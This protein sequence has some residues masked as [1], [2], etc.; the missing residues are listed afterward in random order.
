MCNSIAMPIA[1][2]TR[3]ATTKGVYPYQ[4]ALASYLRTA[5]FVSLF[6]LVSTIEK[7]N[8]VI[9]FGQT[10]D[11]ISVVMSISSVFCGRVSL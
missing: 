4:K 6:R 10:A 1:P 8:K 5:I 3:K 11:Q 9:I 2:T 7:M